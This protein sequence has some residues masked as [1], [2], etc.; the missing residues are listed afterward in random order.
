M[1]VAAA[2]WPGLS[3]G[4]AELWLSDE[5]PEH[6]NFSPES[7]EGFGFSER[8]TTVSALDQKQIG[9]KIPLVE[10]LGQDDSKSCLVAKGRSSLRRYTRSIPSNTVRPKKASCS[11]KTEICDSGENCYRAALTSPPP[12][13]WINPS[14]GRQAPLLL[15]WLWNRGRPSCVFQT[16]ETPQASGVL[17]ELK[18]GVQRTEQPEQLFPAVP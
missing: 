6:G 9:L 10:A 13:G 18:G 3:V 1:A 17:A 8:E 14:R 2:S 11:S 7:L 12:I 5:S 15:P 4:G 16:C